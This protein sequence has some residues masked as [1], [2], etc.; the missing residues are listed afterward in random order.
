[1]KIHVSNWFSVM[2]KSGNQFK[3][4]K[5]LKKRQSVQKMKNH[6]SKWFSFI[7]KRGNQ[8]EKWKNT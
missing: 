6:F 2:K 4:W 1:M 3:N 5:K 7:K 8:K